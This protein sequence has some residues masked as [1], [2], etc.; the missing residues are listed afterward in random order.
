MKKYLLFTLAFLTMLIEGTQ[1]VWADSSPSGFWDQSDYWAYNF[2]SVNQDTKTLNISTA[3]ELAL[4]ANNGDAI[5]HDLWTT[6][7]E[8]WTINLT[9]DIDMSAHFWKP[10]AFYVAFR[11]T[12]NGNGK[13]ISGLHL[14]AGQITTDDRSDPARMPRNGYGLFEI[15]EGTVENLTIDNSSFYLKETRVSTHGHYLGAFAGKLRNGG[16]LINCSVT[17]TTVEGVDYIGGL[18]GMVGTSENYTAPGSIA[19]CSSAATVTGANYVGGLVGQIRDDSSVSNSLYTGTSAVTSTGAYAGQVVGEKNSS[20]V[21]EKAYFTYGNLSPKNSIDKKAYRITLISEGLELN[22]GNSTNYSQS[23][24]TAFDCV[25]MV[26]EVNDYYWAAG[27]DEEVTFGLTITDN[28]KTYITNVR[29]NGDF[30]R[31]G[32][33]NYSFT[34][35]AVD[36]EITADLLEDNSWDQQ[37][38][39]AE[40]FDPDN[41]DSQNK[42]IVI[43]REEELG[44]LAYNVN[45]GVNDYEG[46]TIEIGE[47]SGE[48]YLSL[49]AHGWVPIGTYS[50]PFKGTFDG[51]GRGIR[52]LFMPDSR[53]ASNDSGLFGYV[54]GGTI[55]S[56]RLY[57]SIIQGMN[58]VGGIVGDLS[59]GKV[60]DCYV[61]ESCVIAATG[62]TVGGLVGLAQGGSSVLGNFCAAP[63]G[64]VTR[65]GGLIGQVNYSA[66]VKNNIYG[67]IKGYVTASGAA[68]NGMVSYLIGNINSS[69]PNVRMRNFSIAS[70]VETK[71]NDHDHLAYFVTSANN[72]IT[73]LFGG[74]Q[75]TAYPTSGIVAYNNQNTS[76][77]GYLTLNGVVYAEKGNTLDITLNAA[78]ENPTFSNVSASSGTLTAVSDNQYT[79]ALDSGDEQADVTISA[80]IGDTFWTN[81][82]AESFAAEVGH[83]IT[84][85]TPEQLALL[86]KRVNS[87]ETGF[88]GFTIKLTADIDLKHLT[89]NTAV[90]PHW[91]PIGTSSNPFQGI[92]DGQGHTISN[93]TI[94][95]GDNIS[96]NVGLFGYVK[97]IILNSDDPVIQHVKLV[98][99]SIE[100]RFNVG[101]IAGYLDAYSMVKDCYVGAY[102]TISGATCVGGIAGKT[103]LSSWG[104]AGCVSAAEVTGMEGMVKSNI[105]GIVGESNG[106]VSYN[107]YTGE[108]VSGNSNVAAVIGR[109]GRTNLIRDNY[110]TN[111][112]FNGL[113][114]F[115]V[116]ANSITTK[117]TDGVNSISLNLGDG[118]DDND[119][120]IEFT[121]NY[122]E[123]TTT[124][125]KFY[126]YKGADNGFSIGNVFYGRHNQTLQLTVGVTPTDFELDPE[127][128]EPK[129]GVWAIKANGDGSVL[130]YHGTGYNLTDED[131]TG[132]FTLPINGTNYELTAVK[133][134][135]NFEGAG[136]EEAPYLIRNEYEML[137]LALVVNK[138]ESSFRGKYFRLENNLNYDGLDAS[139]F[140]PVGTKDHPFEGYFDGNGKTISNISE[141][142]N[143]H[144]YLGIF[145]HIKYGKISHLKVSNSTFSSNLDNSYVGGIVGFVKGILTQNIEFATTIEDCIVDNTVNITGYYAGG[146]V[147]WLGDQNDNS[148]KAN[149][150]GCVSAAN[151]TGVNCAGGVIGWMRG[152]GGIQVKNCLYTGNSV[153]KTGEGGYIAYGVANYNSSN[154][155]SLDIYYTDQ[156]LNDINGQDR[157]AY[158]VSAAEG[159]IISHVAPTTAY[160]LTGIQG[161]TVGLT[162]NG[163]Y[164]ATK[165]QTVTFTLEAENGGNISDVKVKTENGYDYN[166][167]YNEGKYSFTINNS[168]PSNYTVSATITMEWEGSGTAEDPYLIPN[169]TMLNLLATRVNNGTNYA[170]KFFKQTNNIDYSNETVT[171]DSNFTP[172]GQE[173]R[174]FMGIY[175]GDGH[176]VKGI[177][178]KSDKR[179]VGF[180]GFLSTDQYATRSGEVRNLTLED[181]TVN[182]TLASSSMEVCTGALA[183]FVSGYIH[184]RPATI[185]NC[186]VTGTSSVNGNFSAG[187]LIGSV[188]RGKIYGCTT[189]AI[190]TA[191]TAGGLVG[192]LR[193]SANFD[194][195]DCLYLGSTVTGATNQGYAI[196]LKEY[197]STFNMENVYY[198]STLPE[199]NNPN[200]V[201]C[202]VVEQT[203]EFDAEPVNQ[204]LHNGITVYEIGLLKYKGMYYSRYQKGDA[205][206]DGEVNITDYVAVIDYI[207]GKTAGLNAFTTDANSDG[208]VNITDAVKV[209]DIIHGNK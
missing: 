143:T 79:L 45:S 22:F 24:I 27:E 80:T 71:I 119:Y 60:E 1:T 78:G 107:I 48:G 138:A 23:G 187:G 56:V 179:Y 124:G 163:N 159:L 161:Y 9:A 160:S 52:S 87:G 118:K 16:R 12:F 174:Q 15:I 49:G 148:V 44:L 54:D 116:L 171:D 182:G 191:P 94:K 33:N 73:L 36:A 17:N 75:I 206:S 152:N 58:R 91:M 158:T 77:T 208:E 153:I 121:D 76:G 8:G 181:I 25:L 184:S 140:Q 202:Y 168:T 193:S 103:T 132:L 55:K 167:V 196:G 110:Y 209:I 154:I 3:A 5:S 164:Y 39:R 35:P 29:V 125:I 42:K 114:D 32:S 26:N 204:Y 93:L 145:G 19:G 106:R 150:E 83:T 90:E 21:I 139:R 99:S 205:N 37:G 120:Q 109:I 89:D 112:K 104:V 169:V 207:H 7:Y 72:A 130:K 62:E 134:A 162:Y 34:M 61:D 63:V 192:D 95:D 117:N 65:V 186:H 97:K 20:S 101:G 176:N 67:G 64:G 85:A 128:Q 92:F 50:H 122:N 180:F 155:S 177:K 2:S 178:I 188:W 46:W 28:T 123:C 190:A 115:D 200:D 195:K 100:G 84:I 197:V 194:M 10:A 147:A 6:G 183:G 86:A 199:S 129:I 166:Y 111:A 30:I 108:N 96:Q 53:V 43:T 198:R 74:E 136:D 201:K 47:I 82:A 175:D 38:F 127:T 40:A 189:T 69:T 149:A 126:T 142:T 156:T 102:V 157:K 98:N 88:A 131:G 14:D 144:Q 135:E 59:S 81:Y 31:K 151:V 70:L 146:I 172:I 18:V 141:T 113:N 133:A 57:N 4:F 105:G 11:G 137:Q 203:A 51:K 170:G 68:G 165:G 13:T 41:I 173:G 66:E 185:E